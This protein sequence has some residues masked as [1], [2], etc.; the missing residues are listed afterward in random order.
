MAEPLSPALVRRLQERAQDPVRRTGAA[1]LAAGAVDLRT[2]VAAA[3]TAAPD[4]SPAFQREVE[5]YLGGINSPLAGLTR[6]LASGDA[7]QSSGLLDALGSL[8]GGHVLAVGGQTVTTSAPDAT[9]AAPPATEPEVRAAEAGL[10]FPLPAELRQL[11]LEVADGGVGPGDGVLPLAELVARHRELTREPAGPQGQAWPAELLPV[12]GQ[13][14]ELVCLD[15][16]TGRLVRWDLEE[17]EDDDE[18]PA[19][20]PSWA[21]S[22][23]PEADSLAAWLTAWADGS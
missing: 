11:Y 21:A 20:H 16:G 8:L 22:F 5:D 12:Q 2:A 6:R 3:P 15:R 10:G 1:A 19:D 18:L 9:A 4:R 7:A 17:L 23:V 13:A 14:W